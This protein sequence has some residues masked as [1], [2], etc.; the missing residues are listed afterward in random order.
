VVHP[1]SEAGAP[2]GNRVIV[3]VRGWDGTDLRDENDEEYAR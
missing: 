2:P 3:E 1:R